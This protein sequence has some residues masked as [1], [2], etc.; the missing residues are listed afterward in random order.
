MRNGT[1]PLDLAI[2]GCGAVIEGLYRGAL[3]KLESR[4]MVRVVAL[5]DP[6][7][8]RTAAL[9]RHFGSA[10]AFAT[11]ERALAETRAH[12]TIVA[13][14][15]GRHA[16]HAL[17]AFA[18]GSNV[19]CEKPMTVA[20]SDAERM[21]VAAREA[22]RVLAVGMVRRM[23]P[24]LAEARALLASGA[25]GDRLRFVYRE[26]LVYSW[27]VS[28]DAA[29]RRATA[30]GGVL[31]DFGSHAIDFLAAL[32]GAPAVDAYADD[33][34]QAGVETNCRMHLAFPDASGVAQLSWSQPL[35]TEL[36][37]AGSA[38]ELALDPGR[39][40]SVRWRRHGGAW[41]TRV[42]DAAWPVDLRPDGDRRTPRTY[43]E[44]IYHQIVQ[45]LRAV[46]HGEPVPASGEEGIAAVRAIEACYEKATALGLPW[47]GT[48]EAAEAEAR[49][50]NGERWAAA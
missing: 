30:G 28:T 33:A 50:W 27:P 48:D 20:A 29:F 15:A 39:I 13:S 5:V 11:A 25:I 31:T 8:D 17:L 24:S 41:Q 44:C 26:G 40:D 9:G 43:Y 6:S 36:R 7:A 34:H 2:I 47:L 18:A 4:G 19:L 38:G 1:P 49:H 12:L 21:I 3:K 46:A 37:V 22:G 23:F 16:E 10:R 14:P 35:V 45:V 32:F 42:S